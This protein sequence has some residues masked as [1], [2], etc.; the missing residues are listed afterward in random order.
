MAKN[1]KNANDLVTTEDS[2]ALL[3][4]ENGINIIR[5][6]LGLSLSSP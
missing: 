4:L 2:N 5:D 3:N 6:N 1:D